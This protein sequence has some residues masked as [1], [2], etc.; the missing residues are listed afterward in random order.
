VFIVGNHIGFVEPIICGFLYQCSYITKEKNREIPII[1]WHFLLNQSIFV[2]REN[3]SRKQATLD[4]IRKRC[5]VI[6]EN[7]NMPPL[8][9]YPEGTNSNN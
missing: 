8:N 6:E 3:S 2:N 5:S 1:G 4:K 9:I 7:Q